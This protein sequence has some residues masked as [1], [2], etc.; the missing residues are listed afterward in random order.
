[1]CLAKA[2]QTTAQSIPAQSMPAPPLFMCIYTATQLSALQCNNNPA[3]P[4]DVRVCVCVCVCVRECASMCGCV[5]VFLCVS[6]KER[7]LRDGENMGGRKRK[8][9]R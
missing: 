7:N 3:N 4:P 5:F 8:F 2:A 1:M 9:H 6:V